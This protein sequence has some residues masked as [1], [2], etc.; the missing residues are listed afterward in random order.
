MP[1]VDNNSRYDHATVKNIAVGADHAG[2]ELKQ[3]VIQLL[4]QRN[5]KINDMGCHNKK[6]VD[7]PDI[8]VDV[9]KNVAS[10]NAQIGILIC[11]SGSGMAITAN[12]IK[13]IRAVNCFNS[14]MAQLAV[15]HNNANILCLGARILAQKDCFDIID[16]FL[17]SKFEQGRHLERIEKITKLTEL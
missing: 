11:G 5:Y 9:A 7:Y 15:G 1:E 12:K 3:E 8:A 6:S 13:N 16:T 17:N 10:G 14:E 4:S 2:F